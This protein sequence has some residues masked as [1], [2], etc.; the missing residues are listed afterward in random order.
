[1][2]RQAA[3]GLA[4]AL[5]N[6][7]LYAKRDGAAAVDCAKTLYEEALQLR[8]D[9]LGATHP[10]TAPITSVQRLWGDLRYST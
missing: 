6:A 7:A 4:A 9:A 3:T 5:N 2:F 10:Q 1:M 8:H